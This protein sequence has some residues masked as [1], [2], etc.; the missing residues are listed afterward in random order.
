VRVEQ[1]VYFAIASE[2]VSAVEIAAAV[3]LEPDEVLVRGS[4]RLEPRPVPR[5]HSW[6]ITARNRTDRL[7][8]QIEDVLSRVAAVE[9]RICRLLDQAG[10]DA[11]ARLE[12]VRTFN[13]PE[14]PETKDDRMGWGIGEDQLRLLRRLGA[15][16]DVDEYDCSWAE[17]VAS[18]S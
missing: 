4:E 9:D 14:E 17:D 18:P 13:H 10:E 3:G 1:Y 15:F 6:Q 2:V 7:D 12:I 5:T 16:I 11:A 8:D